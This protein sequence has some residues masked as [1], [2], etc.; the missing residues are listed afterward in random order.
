FYA[1]TRKTLEAAWVRPRHNGYMSF[2]QAASDRLNAGLLQSHDSL[3]V[4]EDLIALFRHS[5]AN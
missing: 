5:F 1:A 4:V 3:A 2:Q